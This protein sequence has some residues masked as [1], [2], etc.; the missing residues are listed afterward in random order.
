[1][2]WIEHGFLHRLE[3]FSKLEVGREDGEFDRTPK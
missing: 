2:N 3:K 1:M